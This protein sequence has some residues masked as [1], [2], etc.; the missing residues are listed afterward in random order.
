MHR[1][2]LVMMGAGQEHRGEK[3]K[4]DDAIRLVVIDRLGLRRLLQVRIVGLQMFERVAEERKDLLSH[5]SMP[6]SMTPSRVPKRDHSGF[7]LRTRF[8]SLVDRAASTACRIGFERIVR[9]ALLR[10]RGTP[11]R[12]QHPRHHRV[13]AALD[14]RQIDEARGA[15]DQRAARKGE[16]RD[17][18]ESAFG[19]RARAIGDALAAFEHARGSIGCVLAR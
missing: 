19:D 18:L 15:A 16:L 6:P 4:T 9:A 17:R 8:S 14:A 11:L 5:M 12:R 7:T 2:V 1:L 10:A 13:V 3:V